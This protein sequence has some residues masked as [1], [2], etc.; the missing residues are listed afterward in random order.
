[1]KVSTA[2]KVSKIN[3]TN[4]YLDLICTLYSK[5]L[6]LT[7]LY[8]VPKTASK[9]WHKCRESHSNPGNMGKY[10]GNMFTSWRLFVLR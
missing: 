3:E 9:N 2:V 7:R 6:T 4:V 8:S 5:E 1:M 10:I